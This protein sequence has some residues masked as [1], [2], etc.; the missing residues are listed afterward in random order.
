MS[1]LCLSI[2]EK[3][4]EDSV[5]AANYKELIIIERRQKVREEKRKRKRSQSVSNIN[6]EIRTDNTNA[7]HVHITHLQSE[8]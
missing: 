8:I 6:D 5:Y 1:V 4:E 2:E 3:K 7:C